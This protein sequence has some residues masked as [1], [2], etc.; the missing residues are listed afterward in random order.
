MS[1]IYS[2]GQPCVHTFGYSHATVG[3]YSPL[4]PTTELRVQD[5]GG[6]GAAAT[7][8]GGRSVLCEAES[9]NS[10]HSQEESDVPPNTGTLTG[11][12]LDFVFS[13]TSPPRHPPPTT[14]LP[15]LLLG[16]S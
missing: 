10:G 13:G 12:L 2:Q 7:G 9:A 15:G 4:P 6:S 3:M 11:T 8:R 16:V 5:W 14:R 1:Q